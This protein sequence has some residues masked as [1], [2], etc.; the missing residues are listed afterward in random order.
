M[1]RCMCTRM[2][3]RACRRATWMEAAGSH[4]VSD[5]GD[6]S[7]PTQMQSPAKDVRGALGKRARWAHSQ[8]HAIRRDP[9]EF[10]A[11]S[12]TTTGV[13][14]LEKR[15][16]LTPGL[17]TANRSGFCFLPGAVEWFPAGKA[18]RGM[19]PGFAAL[20]RLLEG[21]LPEPA[22]CAGTSRG[23]RRLANTDKW[24]EHLERTVDPPDWERPCRGRLRSRLDDRWVRHG[25]AGAVA[26]DEPAN[27]GAHLR[28][29][30]SG[31]RGVEER[32]V[33]GG[34]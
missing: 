12:N 6:P 15:L 4:V 28:G 13:R 27:L 22:R 25:D 5:P 9:G 33:L 3:E 16:Q 10:S 19:G 8:G 14:R 31:S 21:G 32:A 30:G 20:V 26:R 34:R 29:R 24:F 17:S 7:G 23:T 18:P 1:R 2:P 11:A